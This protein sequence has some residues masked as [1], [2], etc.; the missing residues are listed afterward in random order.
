MA[1]TAPVATAPIRPFTTHFEEFG[2]GCGMDRKGDEVGA[3][4]MPNEDELIEAQESEELKAEDVQPR[5]TKQTPILPSQSDIDEHNIDH[6]PYRAWCDSCVCGR[7]RGEHH[8]RVEGPGHISVISFDYFFI[9][10]KGF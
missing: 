9:G 1:N 5:R 2:A 7:G 10:K 8:S 4:V 6:I 3:E